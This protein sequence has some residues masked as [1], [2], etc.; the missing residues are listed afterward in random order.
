MPSRDANGCCSRRLVAGSHAGCTC[1]VEVSGPAVDPRGPAGGTAL[2]GLVYA[3]DG[4]AP[5]V[6]VLVGDGPRSHALHPTAVWLE[7]SD[8]GS[9]RGLRIVAEE[10]AL[11]LRFRWPQPAE[12]VAGF[13]P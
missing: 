4:G 10:G 3:A 12:H 6:K 13:L 2:A 1:S 9:D 7:K 11:R 8:D 5:E